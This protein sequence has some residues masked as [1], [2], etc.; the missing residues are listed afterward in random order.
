[1]LAD[2][3]N[4]V[5]RNISDIFL[6]LVVALVALISFGAGW[7]LSSRPQ[8]NSIVIQNPVCADESPQDNLLPAVS[9][10]D[11]VKQNQFVGSI[12]SDKYHWPNCPWAKKISSD[13]QVWFDS[14]QEAQKAGYIRCGSFEKYDK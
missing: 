14:E 8:N 1:M 12:N 7:L 3:I 6:V 11:S 4:L 13:N 2:F 5:K 9:Q 10:D